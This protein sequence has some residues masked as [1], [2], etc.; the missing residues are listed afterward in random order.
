MVGGMLKMG[1]ILYVNNIYFTKVM[2]NIYLEKK[3]KN[4]LFFK[5]IK[6]IHIFFFFFK[7]TKI[8]VFY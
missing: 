8:Y 6:Q 1:K 3:M 5:R 7:P 2:L 4:R